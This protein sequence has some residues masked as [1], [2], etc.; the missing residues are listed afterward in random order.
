VAVD[1]RQFSRREAAMRGCLLAS[2][3]ALATQLQAIGVSQRTPVV[4]VADPHDPWG[5]DG[6]IVWMLRALG[7]GDRISQFCNPTVPLEEGGD[8]IWLQPS[9]SKRGTGREAARGRVEPLSRGA[10]R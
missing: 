3:D 1:W 5:E 2:D 4:V 8:R 6:R 10:G 7:H 9:P